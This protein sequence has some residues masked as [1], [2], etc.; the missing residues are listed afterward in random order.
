[1]G[2][3][4]FFELSSRGDLF[5]GEQQLRDYA[6]GQDVEISLGDS[7]QVFSTCEQTGDGDPGKGWAGMK[8]AL[9]NANPHPAETIG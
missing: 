7:A 3:I 2:G 6:S 8:A 5:V 1:M 9:T 4:T